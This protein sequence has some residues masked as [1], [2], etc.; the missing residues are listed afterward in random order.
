M[1]LNSKQKGKRGELQF[2]LALRDAGYKSA[3]R[4][5]Q[6]SGGSESADVVCEEL[7]HLHFEVKRSET[8]HL[9]K[10]MQQAIEDAGDSGKMP[11]VVHRKNMTEWVAILRFED[12]LK[13]AG[14]V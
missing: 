2:A 9:E 1:A 14:G 12:F 10:W 4:G 6:Y 3:R 11:V 7:P 5:Q 8:V 13:M